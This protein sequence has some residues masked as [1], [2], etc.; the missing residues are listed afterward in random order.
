MNHPLDKD[1]QIFGYKYKKYFSQNNN[2][3]Y[4][5]SIFTNIFAFLNTFPRKTHL[6]GKK[7]RPGLVAGRGAWLGIIYL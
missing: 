5:L 1:F 6:S 2:F 4:K 7:Q 3:T